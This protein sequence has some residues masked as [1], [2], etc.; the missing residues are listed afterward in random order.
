[1]LDFLC[2]VDRFCAYLLGLPYN[3]SSIVDC[4][5]LFREMDI[6]LMDAPSGERRHR[7][8]ERKRDKYMNW[9]IAVMD[10]MSALQASLASVACDR[11]DDRK[12]QRSSSG[13]YDSQQWF[14]RNCCYGFL[15]GVE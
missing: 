11:G 2:N 9:S 1:M 12:R 14:H 15:L 5:A 3:G 7:G 6:S 8:E 10:T 4:V 13:D